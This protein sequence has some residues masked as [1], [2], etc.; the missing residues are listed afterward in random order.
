MSQRLT[1]VDDYEALSRAGADTVATLMAVRPTAA[2]VLATGDTP[3]G[4]YRHVAEQR[5]CG[6]LDTSH[7][8]IFQLDEYWG[9]DPEDRR[10]LYGWTKRAILDPW[11]IPAAHVVRLAGDAPDPE[12]VCRAYDQAVEAAGGFDLAV[13]G[14]GPNGHLGFNEPPATP[15]LPT[16]LVTLSEA[17]IA[18]NAHYWGGRNQVPRQALTAGM[19]SLLAA[20][21]ILLVVSGAHKYDILRHT[22]AGPITAEVPASFLQQAAHVSVIADRAAWHGASGV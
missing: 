16:R 1:V 21:H 15:D 20:R 14:L 13:L 17:S 11:G 3:M 19:S 22:V 9:V 7:W 8:R 18:S 4:M 10:S 5:Q 6:K 2:L 12:A